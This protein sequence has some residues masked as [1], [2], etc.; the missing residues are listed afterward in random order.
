MWWLRIACCVC[1]VYG[2]WRLHFVHGAVCFLSSLDIGVL[3]FRRILIACHADSLCKE[4]CKAAGTSHKWTSSSPP[5]YRMISLIRRCTHDGSGTS[6]MFVRI[7]P[8]WAWR[9]IDIAVTRDV[10]ESSPYLSWSWSGST[11]GEDRRD[12]LVGDL[13][14]KKELGNLL[15]LVCRYFCI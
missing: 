13:C 1:T 11:W 9:R 2:C 14:G 5:Q 10:G 4:D 7:F 8:S 6:R 3:N 12:S 15:Y